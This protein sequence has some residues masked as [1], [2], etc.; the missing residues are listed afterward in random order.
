MSLAARLACLDDRARR[1]CADLLD[2]LS[3]GNYR[4]LTDMRLATGKILQRLFDAAL[5]LIQIAGTRGCN[6]DTTP[7]FGDRWL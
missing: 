4:Q 7:Y 6:H 1:Q 3:G 2:T 5:D